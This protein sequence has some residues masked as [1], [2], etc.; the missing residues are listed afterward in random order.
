MK[1]FFVSG[2]VQQQPSDSHTLHRPLFVVGVILTGQG[3]QKEIGI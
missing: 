3:I 1:I 2:Q